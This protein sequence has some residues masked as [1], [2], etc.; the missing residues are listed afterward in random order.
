MVDVIQIFIRRFQPPILLLWMI[1]LKN[2]FDVD[3]CYEKANIQKKEEKKVIF[4]I[5]FGIIRRFM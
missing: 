2:R 5:T 1:E 3:G 4:F